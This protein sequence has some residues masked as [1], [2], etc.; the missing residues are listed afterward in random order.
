MLGRVFASITAVVVSTGCEGADNAMLRHYENAADKQQ[1]NRQGDRH[2][3]RAT[4]RLARPKERAVGS[5]ATA[6]S[7]SSDPRARK[8]TT[9]Y[10]TPRNASCGSAAGA[11]ARSRKFSSVACPL[12]RCASSTQLRWLASRHV[13]AF[14]R[15]LDTRSATCVRRRQ[16][17]CCGAISS[18]ALPVR[19]SALAR[20]SSV[21]AVVVRVSPWQA[22]RDRLR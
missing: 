16:A 22:C 1:Y 5:T 19:E 7:S 2:R 17:G 6:S 3:A 9:C 13:A 10:T 20:G 15:R 14:A 18:S 11:A 12:R 4:R 21:Y 8:C